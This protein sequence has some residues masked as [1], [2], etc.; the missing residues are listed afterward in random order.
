MNYTTNHID[1]LMCVGTFYCITLQC[2][3]HSEF[4]WVSLILGLAFAVTHL[5]ELDSMSEAKLSE[6]VLTNNNIKL[7]KCV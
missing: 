7:E 2:D 3:L 1:W 5:R 6:C 4:F